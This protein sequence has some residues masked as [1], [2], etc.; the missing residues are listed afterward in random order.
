MRKRGTCKLCR[1]VGMKLFLKGE[2]CYS[3]KCPFILR[4]YPPGFPPKRRKVLS[5]SEYGYLLREKQKLKYWYNLKEKQLK[6]IVEEVLKKRGKGEDLAKTLIE[7]LEGR[8]EN[9]IFRSGFAPSRRSARQLISHKFFLVNGEPVNLPSFRV[10]KGDIIEFKETKMKKRIVEEIKR[11]MK[12]NNPLSWLEVDKENLKVKVVDKP[13]GEGISL[14]I[15]LHA[16]F[17]FYSR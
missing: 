7:I 2:K 6:N 15:D 4:P 10:K 16:I 14:P 13:S 17:E 9:V 1:R 11:L 12:K 3:P 5:F 8:L